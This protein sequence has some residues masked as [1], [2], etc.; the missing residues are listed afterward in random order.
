MQS[1]TF[2]YYQEL[3]PMARFVFTIP[4]GLIGEQSAFAAPVAT[5]PART[6]RGARRKKPAAEA[7]L[8]WETAEG[9]VT[10]APIKL[11]MPGT[12]TL[13]APG[14][15]GRMSWAPTP[16][17][18]VFSDDPPEGATALRVSVPGRTTV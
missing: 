3:H 9:R 18:P 1:A 8:Q 10:R 5:R 13:E 6:P 4:P 15:D 2:E 7:T 17:S 11:R 12:V 16:T 14:G